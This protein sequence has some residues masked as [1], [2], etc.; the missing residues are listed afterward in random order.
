MFKILKV[1]PII[2]LICTITNVHTQTTNQNNDEL[3]LVIL[4]HRH[5]D[6]TPI[7]TYPR[8]PYRND[9]FWPDGWGE[10]TIK[11]KNRMY[12]LGLYLAKRYKTFLGSNPRETYI[13]SS[14]SDRC[15]ESVSLILAGL[16]PPSSR[17]K[18]NNNIGN[19][20]QPF[21]I[22]TVP[23]DYDGML[24]PDSFCKKGKELIDEIYRSPIVQQYADK[25]KSTL[26][27]V[28]DNTG[29]SS[30]NL[31]TAEQ[32]FDSLLVE[33]ENGFKL[34][35]WVDNHVYAQLSDIS[36]KTFIFSSLTREIQRLRTGL[37]L[38]DIIQ[39]LNKSNFGG[40]RLYIYST[41]DTQITLFL[42]A[43]RVYN[44]LAPPFGS[45]IMLEIYQNQTNE[46]YIRGF[47]LN[48]TES[49][50]PYELRLGDGVRQSINVAR[51]I[52]TITDFYKIVDDLIPDDWETECN[53]NVTISSDAISVYILTMFLFITICVLLVFIYLFLNN[54]RHAT[55]YRML[56]VN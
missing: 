52:C 47:Y 50:S 18:W 3:K 24:N 1:Y 42:S 31:I 45:A 48:V 34:P 33:K 16:Y 27:Y 39:N 55:F 40:K 44:E 15:L 37:L 4:I 12:N 13:R 38:K 6:R 49:E 2:S 22:Q 28:E 11:G 30:I 7:S 46:P 25:V 17:W 29:I 35:A 51:N 21:P 23:H 56:P 41:H 8:D 19:V 10:L 36:T 5:G 53:N 43:L 14:G 32:I 9:S 54:R 20:W 26:H